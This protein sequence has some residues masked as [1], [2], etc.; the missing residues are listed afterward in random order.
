MFA[1]TVAAASCGG[2][3]PPPSTSDPGGNGER[4]SGNE[5]LGWN[6]TAADG[7]SS[8]PFAIAAY[9][10]GN[11]AELADV[12]CGAAASGAFPCSSRM[13]TMAPGAHA[14]EL[15]SFID[16]GGAVVESQR[17]ATLRV[18]VT[19]T[20]AGGPPASAPQATSLLK[21]ATAWSCG[22]ISSPI[23][24]RRRPRLPPRPTGACSSRSATAASVSCATACSIRAG[25]H[26]PRR[27]GDGC[28]RRWPRRARARRAIRSH[29]LHLRRLHGRG[30]GGD[31]PVPPRALPRS[32]WAP[33]RARRAP[34]RRSSGGTARGRGGDWSGR[35]RLRGV[36]C[37]SRQRPHSG[38]GFVQR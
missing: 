7:A 37:R 27:T 13:P 22:S 19:G 20:T 26:P 29:P 11:R 8:R 23:S 5:R 31:A 9:V 17:S 38:H 30:S 15:V 3:P 28:R 33:R 6:Q 2:S 12:S 18:T 25:H 21:T 16:D 36:R 35:P 10:D 34:R 14:I 32:R 4:I 1:A 24:S